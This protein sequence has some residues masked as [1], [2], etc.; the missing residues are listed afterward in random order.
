MWQLY[1]AE[2]WVDAGNNSYVW[3][4]KPGV[5]FSQFALVRMVRCW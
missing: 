3:M 5:K 1:R 4:C 2:L